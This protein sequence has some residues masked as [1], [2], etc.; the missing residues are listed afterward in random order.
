LV[1]VPCLAAVHPDGSVV[2][3]ELRGPALVVA[4]GVL[5]EEDM[6]QLAASAI[7]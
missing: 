2:Q 6:Q 7:V 5:V 3:E 1:P 4:E